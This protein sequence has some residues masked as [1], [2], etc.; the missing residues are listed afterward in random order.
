M[1]R[2]Q[3]RFLAIPSDLVGFT[4]D[5]VCPSQRRSPL[6]PSPHDWEGPP[7]RDPHPQVMDMPSP[8]FG[9]RGPAN[10]LI[11]CSAALQMALGSR[12]QTD[13]D[14]LMH[15]NGGVIIVGKGPDAPAP[16]SP[17]PHEMG[18]IMEDEEINYARL[19]L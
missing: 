1:T 14:A 4:A 18:K 13:G 11:S 19:Q 15:H 5:D 16:P 12:T 7:L 3:N 9:L 10:D 6:R 2:F 17:P 8:S